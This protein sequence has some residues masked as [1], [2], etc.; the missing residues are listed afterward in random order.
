MPD[1]VVFLAGAGELASVWDAQR[2]RLGPVRSASFAALDLAAP[3]SFDDAVDSL[4]RHVEAAGARSVTVVGL[5]IGAM[6]A[7]RYAARHPVASLVL[8]AGQVKPPRLRMA[9]QRLVLGAVPERNLGLPDGLSKKD[10]LSILSVRVDLTPD[11]PRITAPTVVLCGSDD[12]PNRAAAHQLAG[13][14]RGAQL[15]IVA[16]GGHQLATDSPVPFAEAVRLAIDLA[17]T[18]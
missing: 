11:L 3:F 8:S 9:L 4:R 6:I 13:G 15:R 12:R 14:I 1:L 10:L 5:S 7:T 2:E 18:P 16:G 17:E